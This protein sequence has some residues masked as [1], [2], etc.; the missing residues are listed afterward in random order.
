[1]L[2]Y[3][4][5]S[6]PEA[7][8]FVQRIHDAMIDLCEQTQDR[9]AILGIS[10]PLILPTENAAAFQERVAV[11]LERVDLDHDSGVGID[12]AVR[13]DV[14]SGHTFSAVWYNHARMP[15]AA[16]LRLGVDEFAF[17]R[18]NT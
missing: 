1:M 11:A 2:A 16:L 10:T 6:V 18:Y 15:W 12:E 8:A 9:F 3:S 13:A 7:R 4:R 17:V 14:P 5:M